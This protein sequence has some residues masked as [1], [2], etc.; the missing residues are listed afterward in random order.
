MIDKLLL[1]IVCC[2]PKRLLYWSVIHVASVATSGK[3]SNTIVPELTIIDA[4][5]RWEEAT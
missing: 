5:K 1:N 3:Y 4:L 2:L